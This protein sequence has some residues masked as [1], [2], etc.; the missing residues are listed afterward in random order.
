MALHLAAHSLSDEPLS[1]I[2]NLTLNSSS[3]LFST[4]TSDGWIIY[5]S[6]PLKVVTRRGNALLLYLLHSQLTLSNQLQTSPTRPSDWFSP[7]NEQTSSS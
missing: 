7:S 2:T 6:N 5:N 1:N 4:S 3:S